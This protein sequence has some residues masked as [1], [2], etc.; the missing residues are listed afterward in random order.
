MSRRP[1]ARERLATGPRGPTRSRGGESGEPSIVPGRSEASL[2]VRAVAGL[3][4]NYAMPP[5]GERLSAAE[6]ALI[7]GWI[8][9]GA[10]WPEGAE[11]EPIAPATLE[12]WSFRPV[13]A[14]APPICDDPRLEN[15]IDAFLLVRLREA[16]LDFSQPEDRAALARRLSF[17]LLGLPPTPEEIDAFAADAAP[18]AVERL[19]DRLLASP[20]Y[21]E[22]WARHWLD[23]VR[24]A[25]TSGF[26][27]NVERLTAYPYRD[28]VIDAFNF[29]KPYDRFATEQL[30]G[31]AYGADAATGFLVGGAND[32]VKSPDVALTLM[33]RQDEL[34]DML[35]TAG[36]TFVG[37]TLGC[38]VPQPQVRSHFAA[39]LLRASKPSLPASST[40]SGR[41]RRRTTERN[42]RA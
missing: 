28:Y 39:R 3:D 41:C 10:E 29:D 33:Q 27:T 38:A 1:K 15:P 34:A 42:G 4:E 17:N 5:E 16:G 24:F 36:T 25:E 31:D 22:R 40:A 32:R 13:Q 2:L 23:V 20:R 21:G 37:L 26:E 11:E 8:D 9:R 6:I 35:N 30:A 14:A 19:V 7:R 12:H 18:G